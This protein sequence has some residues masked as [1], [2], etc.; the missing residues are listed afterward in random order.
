MRRTRSQSGDN[1]PGANVTL[2]RNLLH[3]LDRSPRRLEVFFRDDDAG[4]GD[5][6]LLALIDRFADHGLPL[7]LAVI[8]AELSARLAAVL[9]ER[10]V[11]LHQHGY[12]HAN[13]ELEG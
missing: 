8:P 9:V 5:A 3:S 7:D 12:S 13:H 11:G 4:W 1:R 10:P 6:R 2:L